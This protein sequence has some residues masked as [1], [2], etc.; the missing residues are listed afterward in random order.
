M[1][2]IYSFALTYT[3]SIIYFKFNLKSDAEAASP[4]LQV[5]ILSSIWFSSTKM[6]IRYRL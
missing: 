5:S 2:P 6:L 4:Y 1:S 3:S